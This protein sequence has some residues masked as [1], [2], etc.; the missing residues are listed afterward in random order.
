MGQT[1]HLHRLTSDWNE[2]TTTWLNWATPGGDFD[3]SLS[4]S[5]YLPGQDNCLLTL[6]ITG[7]VRAWVSGIHPN[8][9]L[10][11]YSTGSGQ[12]ILYGSKEN[13]NAVLRPRLSILHT[14]P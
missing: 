5:A 6:D 7:L 14:V 1:T 8:Y 13:G 3:D 9:G 2:S 10:L 4:Y 11:L 12:S